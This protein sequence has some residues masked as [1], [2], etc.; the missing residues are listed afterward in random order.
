MIR[1]TITQEPVNVRTGIKEGREWT[2]REQTA[3]VHNGHAFPQRFVI[4]L[5]PTSQPYAPGDYSLDARSV[6]IGQYGELQFARN[7]HLV[8]D[9]T[10]KV[11]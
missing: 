6:V 5:G 4:S 8:P 10:A 11:A 3:Y 2:R 9:K 7:L 1:I